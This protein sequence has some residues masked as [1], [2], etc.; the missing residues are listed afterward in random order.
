MDRGRPRGRREVL[1]KQ[2]QREGAA[3]KPGMAGRW[4]VVVGVWWGLSW[5]GGW[6]GGEG[7]VGWAGRHGWL[8]KR[9]GG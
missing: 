1:W 7:A 8:A 9:H 6:G 3:R 4:G 5:L 2:K